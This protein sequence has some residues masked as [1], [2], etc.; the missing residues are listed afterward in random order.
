MGFSKTMLRTLALGVAMMS[1]GHAVAQDVRTIKIAYSVDVLDDTQ[2]A[3]LQAVQARVASINEERKDIK[4]EL[5]V[6]DA[7]TSV[8]K[9]IS[10]VQTALIKDPDVLIF[11]A[12]DNVGSL[13]AMQ[14]AKDAG[15]LILDRRPTE[16]VGQ[17]TDVAFYGS[18]EGRYSK[19]T[20]DW[21]NRQLEANPDLVLN[22][23]A[24]YGAPAQTAQLLRIDA[25]KAL[26]NEKPD[27]V[28]IIQEGYGNWLTAT[29]Q[30]MAQD[31]LL[32]NPTMN[33]I[34]TA[35]DIMALGVANT[36]IANG[37]TD[38][39]VSGYDL[40]PDGVQRVKDAHSL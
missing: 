6:Y 13:P 9:Q 17:F 7:Q 23:G 25:I 1:L 32:A 15:V 36:L 14:A 24:I 22:I 30:N 31:W 28:K 37:R 35:N 18:D 2:N 27:R 39:L 38:V 34:A 4:V 10:D 8:D 21:I 26:A 29:A 33:Y 3:V 40:T 12:V 16:P 19:A 20:V 5:D 11:S